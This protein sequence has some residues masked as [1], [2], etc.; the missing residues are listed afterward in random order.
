MTTRVDKRWKKVESQILAPIRGPIPTKISHHQFLVGSKHRSKNCATKLCDLIMYDTHTNQWTQIA[1]FPEEAYYL[2]VH[3]AETFNKYQ[4]KVYFWPCEDFFTF[5]IKTRQFNINEINAE[6]LD[7]SNSKNGVSVNEY[8]HF[9][10]YEMGKVEHTIL[11]TRDNTFEIFNPPEF[12]EWKEIYDTYCIYVKSKQVLLLIGGGTYNSPNIRP[13]GIWKYCLKKKKWSQVKEV[14]FN[15]MDVRCALSANEK[16]VIIVGGGDET[17]GTVGMID[18]DKIFVLDIT[19]DNN[20]KLRECSI[21]IPNSQCYPSPEIV[22]MGG[23][24]EHELLVI[25][26]IKKLF[27]TTEFKDLSLPPMYIMK[28]IG[29]W[30][31]QEELHWI[32][33]H[34]WNKRSDHYLMTLSQILSSLQ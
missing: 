8:I 3:P 18:N 20:Y 10:N 31:N 28:M 14:A 29:L 9:I 1:T 4:N 5:D 27:K 2:Y 25:G 15:L 13:F 11:N 21:K 16:Y 24:I 6:D 23:E 22:L 34:W 26:W 12:Q 17:D 32:Q 30:Y 19:D 7:V 33:H